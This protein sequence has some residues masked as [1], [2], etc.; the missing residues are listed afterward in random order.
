[1]KKKKTGIIFIVI[2]TMLYCV[3]LS[4]GIHRCEHCGEIYFGQTYT[5]YVSGE[6]QTV[7]EE[8]HR[9]YVDKVIE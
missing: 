2:S 8:C 3:I 4:C 6:N 9:V 5:Q 1:M 7:C